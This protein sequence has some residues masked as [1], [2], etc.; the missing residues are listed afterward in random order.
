MAAA[1]LVL[2]LA[3]YK[4]GAGKR[5]HGISRPCRNPTILTTTTGE[6][7]YER[8][9]VHEGATALQW[10]RNGRVVRASHA[11]DRPRPNTDTRECV[12]VF[13]S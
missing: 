13:R 6:A 3:A 4:K 11:C 1:M 7:V 9:N 5:L 10:R 8:Q 2:V 12:C